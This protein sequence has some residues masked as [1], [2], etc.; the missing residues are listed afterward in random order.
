[1]CRR[2]GDA[3]LDRLDMLLEERNEQRI[4]SKMVERSLKHRRSA[5]MKRGDGRAQSIPPIQPACGRAPFYEV[6]RLNTYSKVLSA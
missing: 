4:I 6:L 1:M 3:L 5:A 2:E